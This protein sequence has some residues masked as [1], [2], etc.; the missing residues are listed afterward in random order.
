MLTHAPTVFNDGGEVYLWH[1]VIE[2]QDIL[3]VGGI[4]STVRN[5][6]E[7]KRTNIPSCPTSPAQPPDGPQP[8]EPF[9]TYPTSPEPMED[10]LEHT[11]SARHA[12][13][14]PAEAAEMHEAR[15]T[16]HNANDHVRGRITP[17]PPNPACTDLH[18]APAETATMHKACL[19]D[20]DKVGN[21]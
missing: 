9:E 20:R 8:T 10:T 18:D 14:A 12:D 1:K 6:G 3:G 4:I 15:R 5:D 7:D 21:A 13:D 17:T 11:G 2:D 19:T 16:L